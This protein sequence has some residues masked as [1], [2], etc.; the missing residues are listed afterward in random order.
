MKRILLLLVFILWVFGC[1]QTPTEAPESQANNKA[2]SEIMADG[3]GG[4]AGIQQPDIQWEVPPDIELYVEKGIY[5]YIYLLQNNKALSLR[6]IYNQT[7]DQLW[8][9]YYIWENYVYLN[10]G[11]GYIPS[12]SLSG[13]KDAG[14]FHLDVDLSQVPDF[15]ISVGGPVRITA[16]WQL[17]GLWTRIFGYYNIFRDNLTG[18]TSGFLGHRQ[19]DSAISWIRIGPHYFSEITSAGIGKTKDFNAWFIMPD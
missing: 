14:Y 16:H 18:S 7:T 12:N 19:T 4:G 8:I 3:M 10:R 13:S 15:D 17:T 5:G 9:Y 1:E 2:S 11:V 6:L